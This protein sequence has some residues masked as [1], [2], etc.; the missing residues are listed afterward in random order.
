M[1][2][3]GQPGEPE[4][5]LYHKMTVIH[6]NNVGCAKSITSIICFL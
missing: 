2:K 6:N 4:K 5:T 1:E 3:T